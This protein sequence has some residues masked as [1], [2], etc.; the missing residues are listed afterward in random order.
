M[1]IFTDLPYLQLAESDLAA[2]ARVAA[3]T[4]AGTVAKTAQ[5]GAKTASEGLHRFVEGPSA[6]G[7]SQAPFD[8]SKRAFW[9]DFSSVAEKK[10]SS[11]GTS[12]MGKGG[13]S[14]SRPNQPA[15]KKD[16]WDDW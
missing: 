3:G 11:I 9:D 4:V 2:Q 5:S 8:E 14:N 12:A 6:G 16:E 1:N 7:Y 13:S 10:D 15:A